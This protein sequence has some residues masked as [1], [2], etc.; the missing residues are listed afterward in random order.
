MYEIKDG[1]LN[2]DGKKVFALGQSYYPSFHHA[3]YPVPPTGDRMGEMRKD[4]QMMHHMGFNHVRFAG[5]G[6]TKLEADGTVSVETP[7]VDAMI[8]EADRNEISSSIRLQGYV[9]NLR[10]HQDVLMI[11]ENGS[12]QDTKRWFDFIQTTLHHPGMLEDNAMA[13]Q[14]LAKHFEKQTGVVA[15]QIYNEPHYPGP[16]RF[17]YH[18][19]AIEA[20]R[21][22]LVEQGV[23]TSGEAE[24]YEPPRNRKDQG[25]HMWALWRLFI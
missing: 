13:T 8:A 14:A 21:K 17:D 23:L 24:T 6:K 12:P 7:F 11:D 20:Y 4:L 5:L 15:F 18:L 25:P 9:I 22:H 2:K 19:L 1:I 3:K 10:G 16:G